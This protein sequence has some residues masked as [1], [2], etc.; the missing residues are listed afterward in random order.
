MGTKSKNKDLKKMWEAQQELNMLINPQWKVANNP[1]YRAVYIELVEAIE[2]YNSW[3]WWK[4]NEPDVDQTVLELIDCIHFILSDMDEPPIADAFFYYSGDLN[5]TDEVEDLLVA[6]LNNKSTKYMLEYM[7][8]LAQHL[9]YDFDEVKRIYNGKMALNIFRQKNGYQ[10]GS[11]I[12][13]WLGE[14]DNEYLTRVIQ[15]TDNFD[16]INNLLNDR[17]NEVLEL[18]GWMDIE[19]VKKD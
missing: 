15:L 6:L 14:E 19:D 4:A 12:K 11:Y 18:T 13:S 3:K 16:E 9:D 5:F 1:W 17:Y 7:F 8:A 10:D 2:H